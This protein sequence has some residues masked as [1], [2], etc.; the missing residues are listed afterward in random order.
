[1]PR[2][3]PDVNTSGSSGDVTRLSLL[4]WNCEGLKGSKGN[5]NSRKLREY[6]IVIFDETMIVNEKQEIIPIPGFYYKVIFASKK[7]SG[8]PFRVYYNAKL[9]KLNTYKCLEN[10]II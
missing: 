2:H 3:T 6:D 5:L 9:G 7:D 10:F 8:R 4:L 1:M